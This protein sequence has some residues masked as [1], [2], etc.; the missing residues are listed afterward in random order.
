MRPMRRKSPMRIL[1]I[2]NIFGAK[3]RTLTQQNS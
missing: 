1:V 3:S 2:P